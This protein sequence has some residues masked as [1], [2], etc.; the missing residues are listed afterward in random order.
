MLLW[1]AV[2]FSFTSSAFC[3]AEHTAEQLEFFEQKIR[4]L[5][6]ENCYTCHSADTNAQGGL[7]VDDRNGLI[8]GGNRAAAVVPGKPEESLLL[9]AVSYADKRLQMPPGE[10]LSPEQIADLTQWIADGAAWPSEQAAI[11]VSAP[12]AEY[13]RL[14]REHW[15]W[16]PLQ[17]VEP[18][19]AEPESW[20][21]DA[22]DHFVL[23]KLNAEN[24]QP[25]ADADRLTL[26][27]RVTF[28]LTGL[29]PTLAEVD[30]FLA[31]QSP[32]AYEQV[33]DRLLASPA[34]GER[35]GRHW[36]DVARYGESTGSSRNVPLPHAWR[37]RD[38]VIDSFNADKPYDQFI[39]E[40]IAGD[41]MPAASEEQRREQ[42]IATGFLALGVKDVNQ[43][44][45]VRFIMDNVDEQI[46]TVSRSVLALTASCARCHDHK[47]DPIP[48]R[49][50]YALAGIFRSSE[51]CAGVRN[52]M[53]GGGLDYYDPQA[54]LRLGGEVKAP[55]AAKVA[56]AKAR[57]E[58]AQAAWEAI[59]GTPEGLSRGPN[60]R[61][62][63][64]A[65]R[66]KFDEAQQAYLELSDPSLQGQAAVGVRDAKEVGDTEYRIRGEAELL[67]PVVPRGFPALVQIPNAPAI[68]AEQSG[69]LELAQWLTSRDNPLTSRVIVNRVWRHLFGRGIVS[70]VDNFGTTGDV[71]THPELL[72]H[73]AASFVDEGWS[74]KRL[75]R[76]L[77]LTRTYQL[78]STTVPS[79]VAVD[80]ANHW[81]WRHT[82]R[83]LDAE[84]LRDATLAA[85]GKLIASRPEGSPV[86]ELRVMELQNNSRLARN[87][88]E[89]ANESQHRSVYLPLVRSLT[90]TSLQVFDFAEQGMVSGNRDVTTVATQCLYLLNDPFI[91]RQS[92]NL[93]QQLLEGEALDDAARV[94]QAYRKIL[95][96]N[97]TA[98]EATR[99]AEYL[100]EFEEA[101]AANGGIERQLVSTPSRGAGS[102]AAPLNDALATTGASTPKVA[103]EPPPDP[104]QIVYS[105]APVK[106]ESLGPISP[107]TAAW[108]TFCQALFGSVECRYLK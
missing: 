74:I 21:R 68:P 19:T 28:D 89:A 53:G 50:Y 31:D 83:R 12:N 105:D 69:R 90:P 23:A 44:F 75:V 102:A 55:P 15:A 38:Y 2:A 3:R 65:F 49:D 101:V 17:S 58:E 7:R 67:G 98:D 59:R 79:N 106:A 37:Y 4:P 43:R 73:L 100:R 87:I 47:F 29:P 78:D 66:V 9:R 25:V 34:F 63:Q 20:P 92:L 60:G 61:P 107:R 97:A 103:E 94:N 70:S 26:I 36:L 27:R 40:Q 108:M 76:R 39:C 48:A 16:Q 85:A 62:K 93:S 52:K 77:V 24:L 84:E 8:A 33:V 18:P 72:D 91:R 57:L 5:L 82:P 22:V 104:D 51:L 32:D 86:T 45:K 71:P 30:A 13:D 64:R 56:K 11:D 1:A 81:N 54:L 10:Q 88:E 42:L 46:D 6:V 95:G 14:R 80:P 96:R 99:A 35:W 41:L